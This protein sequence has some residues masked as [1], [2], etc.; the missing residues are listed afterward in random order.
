MMR[1]TVNLSR[2]PP[3]NLRR[4]RI[5]WGGALAVLLAA[6]VA[7]AA[8]ALVGWLGSRQIQARTDA[9]RRQMAP[10]QL[11]ARNARAPLR[12]APTRAFLARTQFL[13]Q[14]IARKSVSWTGLFERLEHIQPPGVEL[15]S[16]RPLQRNGQNAVD[17]RFASQTFQPAIDF[18]QALETS[19][20][21]AGARVERV[22]QNA[23]TAPGPAPAGAAANAEP[24]FQFELTALYQPRTDPPPGGSR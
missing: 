20:D 16:L 17:L 10:L 22:S 24:R 6:L 21:F 8:T 12:S 18:V 23:G 5:V 7:L 9:L 14:L 15:I 4:A 3:E 1:V 13:N 2:R 19:G 11:A